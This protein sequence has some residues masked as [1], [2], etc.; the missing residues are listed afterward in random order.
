[1]PATA[2]GRGAQV[3]VD[4]TSDT[5]KAIR[6]AYAAT[7]EANNAKVAA[8]I[9]AGLY[10]ASDIK[11]DGTTSNNIASDIAVSPSVQPKQ[12]G[13]L[14]LGTSGGPTLNAGTGVASGTQ[15]SGSIWIRTDGAAGAR[16]YVSQGGGTWIPIATV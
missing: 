3:I 9:A 12:A 7:L 16:I 14:V 10:A 2:T 5:A 6:G 1:M 15:P 4:P 11:P 13:S 8:D